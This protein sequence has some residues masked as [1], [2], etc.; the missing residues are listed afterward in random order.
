MSIC[1]PGVQVSRQIAILKI[2][3]AILNRYA[4]RNSVKGAIK[5][6]LAPWAVALE[7]SD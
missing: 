1:E 4:F 7:S 2:A 3:L 5:A 6:A